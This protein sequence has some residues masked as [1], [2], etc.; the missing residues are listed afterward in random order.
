MVNGKGDINYTLWDSSVGKA[1][2]RMG[3]H[4]TRTGESFKGAVITYGNRPY[5]VMLLV[6]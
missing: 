1:L 3:K 6:Y 5:T 4:G 2:Y